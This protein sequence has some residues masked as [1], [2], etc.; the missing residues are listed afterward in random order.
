MRHMKKL[1]NIL[2][3][4]VRAITTL[5]V[6]NINVSLIINFIPGKNVFWSTKQY[7]DKY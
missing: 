4:H 7:I 2:W 3:S 6:S 5:S 1:P